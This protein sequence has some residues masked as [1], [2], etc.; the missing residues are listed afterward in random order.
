[1]DEVAVTA[2]EH[3]WIG[4][5]MLRHL[6]IEI[7]VI[8]PQTLEHFEIFVVIDRGQ[9]FAQPAELLTAGRIRIGA[10]LRKRRKDVVLADRKVAIAGVCHEPSPMRVRA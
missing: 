2:F 4:C 3:G 6:R 8:A 10:L 7:V 5:R 1:L 9:H